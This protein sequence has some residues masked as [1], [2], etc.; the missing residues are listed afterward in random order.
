MKTITKQ[1]EIKA[2]VDNED[3]PCCATSFEKGDYCVFY[4]TRSQGKETCVF[5]ID[6]EEMQRRDNGKGTLIPLMNC[7][8]WSS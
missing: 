7:P 8:V 4:R 6:G 5:A 1:I 3:H 2:F